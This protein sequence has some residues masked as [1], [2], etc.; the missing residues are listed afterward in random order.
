MEVWSRSGGF[1]LGGDGS[2]DRPFE[3]DFLLFMPQEA[4][5]R[6]IYSYYLSTVN[7]NPEGDA[8]LNDELNLQG[9]GTAA[10]FPFKLVLSMQK[11]ADIIQVD[12]RFSFTFSGWPILSW[13]WPGLGIFA[14][15]HT[16]FSLFF[17]I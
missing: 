9:L 11:I 1:L 13:S 15:D 7:V 5:I 3:R 4:S 16:R 10:T 8:N 17:N 12:P 6:T 14:A 2:T